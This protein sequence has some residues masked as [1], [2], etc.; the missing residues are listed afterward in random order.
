MSS[1]FRVIVTI[2]EGANPELF[3][4]LLALPREERSERLRYL[5]TTGALVV[6]GG[7]FAVA[8][9][10]AVPGIAEKASGDGVPAAGDHAVEAGMLE[11]FGDG[12]WKAGEG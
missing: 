7:I 6:E 5:A 8:G 10:V 4:T 9:G 1:K 11:G 12:G 3:T 2:K